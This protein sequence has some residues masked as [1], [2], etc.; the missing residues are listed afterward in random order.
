MSYNISLKKIIISILTFFI[1]FNAILAN[2]KIIKNTKYWFD[3]AIKSLDYTK[4][5]IVLIYKK[6]I[7]ILQIKLSL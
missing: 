2:L 1:I 5:N 4:E 7:Y 3:I 6:D